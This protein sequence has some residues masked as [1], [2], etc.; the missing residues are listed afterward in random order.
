MERRAR[1]YKQAGAYRT[2]Q[3]D[4]PNIRIDLAQSLLYLWFFTL[5]QQTQYINFLSINGI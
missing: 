5:R 1:N 4:E 2:Y 3:P